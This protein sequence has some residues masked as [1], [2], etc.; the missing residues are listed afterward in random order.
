MRIIYCL[1][2]FMILFHTARGQS[3]DIAS[4]QSIT[5]KQCIDYAMEHQPALRQSLVDQEIAQKDIGISLSEWMPQISLNANVQKNIEIQTS[6]INGE[7]IPL[8]TNYNSTLGASVNQVIFSN[9]VL[10]AGKTASDYRLQAEQNT[11]DTKINLVVN[12]SKAYYMVLTSQQQIGVYDQTIERLEKNLKDATSQYNAGVADKIDYKRAQISLNNAIAERKGALES[13]KV[14][15]AMLK[16]LMGYPLDSDISL[17]DDVAS[18]ENEVTTDTLQSL[19]YTSRIEYQLLQTQMQLA[20]ANV[21][22]YKQ[23]YIPT[24]SAFFNY[25]FMYLNNEFSELY[26]RDFPNSAVGLTLSLPIFEG[27]RKIRNIQKSK[28]QLQRLEIQE[29]GLQ[30]QINSEYV[31][32]LG[33][34][35][36]NLEQLQA[37]KENYEIAEDVYNTVK[38]QYREGIKAYLEVI[39]AESDL[40]TSQLNYLNALLNVLSSKLDVEKAAGEINIY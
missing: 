21:S 30:Q 35:K 13:Y 40:R 5:L 17:A 25:N 20:E 2:A 6:V 4:G 37:S 38:L 11:T 27:T 22:Y 18:M 26:N 7:A 19:N 31:Q 36:S 9:S 1:A 39:V 14:Q 23:G 12:V 28:L 32:A 29:E 33:T 24:L 16:Q 8:G 34:Y 15:K 10:L 3:D